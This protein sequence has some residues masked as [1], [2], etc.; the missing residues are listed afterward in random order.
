MCVGISSKRVKRDQIGLDHLLLLVYLSERIANA[1]QIV[2]KFT[3]K[4][5][6]RFVNQMA[7]MLPLNASLQAERN[8]ESH[9]D[10]GKVNE[11]V[12]PAMRRLVWR[13]D[14]DHRLLLR[15]RIIVLLVQCRLRDSL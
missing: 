6:T 3:A 4:I 9:R 15:L 2:L 12:A 1:A 7:M 5:L 11:D 8:E 14:V 10:G 13:V